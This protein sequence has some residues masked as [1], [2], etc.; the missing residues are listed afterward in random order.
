MRRK[1]KLY[2]LLIKGQFRVW[3]RPNNPIGDYNVTIL[4]SKANCANCLTAYRSGSPGFTARHRPFKVAH[5][6]R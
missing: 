5:T 1:K 4:P 3:C 2:H 6:N